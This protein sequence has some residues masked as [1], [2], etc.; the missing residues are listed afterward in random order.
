MSN[1]KKFVKF[2]SEKYFERNFLKSKVRKGY[3]N[4]DILYAVKRLN[5]KFSSF[6]EIGCSGGE[7]LS[8]L[9]KC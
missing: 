7:D 6:L 8:I 3:L 2:D 1:L 5:I 4:Y 9:K